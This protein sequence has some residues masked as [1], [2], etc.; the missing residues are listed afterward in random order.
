MRH[1]CKTC[2]TPIFQLRCKEDYLCIEKSG[3]CRSCIFTRLHQERM[4]I[5]K[6]L[7]I[8]ILLNDVDNKFYGK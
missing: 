8:F 6:I 4:E 1:R 5:D 7:G 3:E 2:N